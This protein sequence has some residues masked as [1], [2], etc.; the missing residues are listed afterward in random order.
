MV[1][2]DTGWRGDSAA[3]A[4]A[5]DCL[6]DRQLVRSVGAFRPFQLPSMKPDINCA[7]WAPGFGAR[8]LCSFGA[9]ACFSR[10]AQLYPHSFPHLRSPRHVCWVDS[11]GTRPAQKLL[12]FWSGRAMWQLSPCVCRVSSGRTSPAH[13]CHVVRTQKPACVFSDIPG[14]SIR[15]PAL[16]INPKDYG[17][18]CLTK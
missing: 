3:A 14:S 18:Y 10:E 7:G 4:A 12:T 13:C 16:G 5:L 11:V 8:S 6:P 2:I 17:R 9:V 1:I 15:S